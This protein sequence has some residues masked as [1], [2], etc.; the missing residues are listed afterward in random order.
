MI[1]LTHG[2]NSNPYRNKNYLG[3]NHQDLHVSPYEA[4]IVNV[5][6]RIIESKHIKQNESCEACIL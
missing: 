4:I 6:N 1:K 3:G 5:A 2:L